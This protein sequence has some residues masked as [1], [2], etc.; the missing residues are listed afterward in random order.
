MFPVEVLGPR[1][2]LRLVER[3]HVEVVAPE[4]GREGKGNEEERAWD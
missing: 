4:L 2:Q 1:Q 3:L